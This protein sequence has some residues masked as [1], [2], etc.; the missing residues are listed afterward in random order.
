MIRL[1]LEW[2]YRLVKEPK[3]LGRMMRL[4]KYILLA[5]RAR[6]KR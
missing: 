3:R 6:R 4:P 2:L 1:Q 5:F